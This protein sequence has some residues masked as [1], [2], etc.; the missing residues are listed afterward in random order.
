MNGMCEVVGLIGSDTLRVV[1]RVHPPSKGGRV[2]VA[3][4]PGNNGKIN[5]NP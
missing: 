5:F 2:L 1:Y 3:C 4:G